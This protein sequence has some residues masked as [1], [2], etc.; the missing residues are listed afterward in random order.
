VKKIFTLIIILFF[1]KANVSG[2]HTLGLFTKAT[3]STDGYVL[4]SPDSY[5]TRFLIDKCGK[6]V[7]KWVT[8]TY[9]GLDAFL[10]PN[11]NLLTTG[12]LSDPSFTGSGS[13]G[14]LIEIYD[15]DNK[16]LWS[17][18]ISDSIEI[19][20]HDVYP[21]PNGHILV[22]IWD[23]HTDS[24]AV[25]NGR[26]TTGHGYDSL[27]VWSAKIEEIE[28]VGSNGAN[29]I[30][31][32]RLWD[33]LIQD[34]DSTKL[35]YGVI[36]DHPER[37]NINF[38]GAGPY[39]N[40]A[41][42]THLNSVT[43]NADLDQV[44]ISIRNMSEIYIID[45]STSIPE[46][47]SRS[48]GK[49]G[50]GGDFLYRWGNP[51]AYNRGS[52]LDQRLFVQ[53]DASWIPKGY[54]DENKIMVFNNGTGRPKGNYSSIE[55]ISPPVDSLGNYQ[56][57][58]GNA[59]GPKESFWTYTAVYPF[60]FYSSVQGGAQRLPN[61]NTLICE[62][63]GGHFF[64]IDTGKNIVWDYINPIS[65][66]GAL[67][68]TFKPVINSVYRATLY[69]LTYPGLKHRTL[70]PGA[71]LEL[72]PLK[73]SCTMT[74]LFE[75]SPIYKIRQLKTYDELTGIA[76]SA[77]AGQ[78]FIKGVVHS[79]S[80]DQGDLQFSLIDSTGA[81]MVY[82]PAINYYSPSIGDSI[83][84][85]GHVIQT[86]GV[87]Q[88]QADTIVG[89]SKGAWLETPKTVTTLDESTEANLV[90]INKVQII[91]TTSWFANGNPFD[92]N[93][94]N[95]KDTFVMRINPAT[96][97]YKMS[98]LNEM[99][100]LTGI[101][102]QDITT[103][104]YLGN[105]FIEPRGLFD[106][107]HEDQ[108]YKIKQIRSQNAITGI[109]DSNGSKHMFLVKGIVQSPSFI[110]LGVYFSI[111]DNTGS[112]FALSTSI[113]GVGYT[114]VINDSVLIR[115][116]LTQINGVVA[117]L[118]DSIA[119]LPNGSTANFI[120]KTIT[121]LDETTE[122]TLVKYNKAWII[123]P[124]QWQ[125][126]GTGFNVDITNGTDTIQLFI[127]NATDLFFQA[128]PK[129]KF[130]VT[131]IGSQNK[132]TSPYLGGYQLMPRGSFDIHL[133]PVNQYKIRQVKP[134]DKV[135]GIADSVN[136]YC[137]LKGVVQSQNLSGSN[138][139]AYS[140]KDSTG[141]ITITSEKNVMSYTA[142]PGDSIAV[143]GL[144]KQDNGLTHFN[145]DSVNLIHRGAQLSPV[146]VVSLNENTES[147]LVTIKDLQLA[148]IPVW[149]TTGTQGR[150]M[151]KAYKA[152]D[153]I[154][155]AIV[156]GTDLFSNTTKPTGHFDITGIGSQ[157]DAT[158]P[159]FKDYFIIPRSISD[160]QHS[161]GIEQ[162]SNIS[163]LIKIYPNP[164]TNVINI[165][166]GFKMDKIE[167]T[168]LLGQIIGY[169]VN[170][171]NILTLDMSPMKPGIYM[172]R[173]SQGSNTSYKK[174]IK[175]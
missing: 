155:I 119:K 104:P 90:K 14:G 157:N 87:T 82:S 128:P 24:D 110:P 48:G 88:Y 137:I 153:T 1:A 34:H 134:I 130:N 169:Y 132:A 164:T 96:D 92:V 173:I 65:A 154:S 120:P 63:E 80:F 174:I 8:K 6:F 106:I 3:G 112:I 142:N 49:H 7:H 35:N 107:K 95:G 61:G 163:D 127:A 77:G 68:Q 29:I 99:F 135:T 83:L 86:N 21:M 149:D 139:L 115:G 143:S 45:H 146:V 97:L 50:K 162:A 93:V 28:P 74:T 113:L 72:F 71:P 44:M 38:L 170:N 32:W 64:E 26:D 116:T 123:D 36:A 172:I 165:V 43:Y 41:D 152:S 129:C 59:F 141:A 15:W 75:V 19:Q 102:S 150:M 27:P 94:T 5:N 55:I 138:I 124:E 161:S 22:A 136:L 20:N 9:P 56:L 98:Q 23:T 121:S 140:L 167:I 37:L 60:D 166:S 17:Y 168:D 33:H 100:D 91:D 103:L 175:E 114:P 118:I 13:A 125:A 117:I 66:Q 109:A 78:G 31:E 81:I 145:N 18:T 40:I 73:Y 151:V 62:A 85:K 108:F 111:K 16:L 148:D 39:G 79:K 57:N 47:A 11:G 52:N 84:V 42:W 159:Y 54:P 10:L 30:W 131:G 158:A 25:A 53:H 147:D 171:S 101:S 89:L 51:Q 122:A 58:A 46:A 76:D 12:R 69:N 144:V 4:F 133:M 70:I 160:I 156:S 105:Y 126:A 2:Q 67:P